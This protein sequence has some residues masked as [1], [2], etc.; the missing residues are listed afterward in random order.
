MKI[1]RNVRVM[2]RSVGHNG[3]EGFPNL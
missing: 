2:F 1:S 3:N